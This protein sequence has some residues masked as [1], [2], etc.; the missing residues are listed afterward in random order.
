MW[1]L[2]P[3]NQKTS[4]YLV[5]DLCDSDVCVGICRNVKHGSI[6]D[7]TPATVVWPDRNLRGETVIRTGCSILTN[8]THVIATAIGDRIIQTS[9]DIG[10]GYALTLA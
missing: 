2:E 10:C 6:S 1:E 7:P 3:M 5:V 4:S 9:K 8:L